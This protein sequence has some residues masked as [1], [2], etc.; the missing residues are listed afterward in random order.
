VARYLTAALLAFTLIAGAGCEKPPA[1]S[2]PKTT[3]PVRGGSLTASVRSQPATFNRFAPNGNQ[4]A[5]DALTRLTHAPLVRV[6]RATGD[7]EPWLAEKWTTSSDGRTITLT[8]RDGITFSDGAP[9]TSADV[10]FTFQA[11]YDP[12][13]ASVLASGV[14]V[15]R[16]IRG[17]SSSRSPRRSPPASRCS[18]MSRSIRSTYCSRRSRRARSARRGARQRHRRRSRVSARSSSPSTSPASA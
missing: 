4:A 14:T 5:V 1:T 6:N 7:P 17:R 2:T 9:F 11:L 16:R 18:T 13:V 3:G 15:R 8:L 10:L 12:K